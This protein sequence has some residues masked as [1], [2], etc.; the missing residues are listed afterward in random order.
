MVARTISLVCL[1]I[2]AGCQVPSQ[3]HRL[4]VAEVTRI[5]EAK[6]RSFRPNI[7]HYQHWLPPRYDAPTDSWFVAFRQKFTR[8]AEFWV[9]VEDKTGKAYIELEE[10]TPTI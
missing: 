3:K 1:L 6:T 4:T 10:T 9:R 8:Y 2:F 7:S 5:A